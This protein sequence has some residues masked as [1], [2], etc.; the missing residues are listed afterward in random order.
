MCW[1][2]SR[3]LWAFRAGGRGCWRRLSRYKGSANGLWDDLGHAAALLCSLQMGTMALPTKHL[4]PTDEKLGVAKRRHFQL[5]QMRISGHRA[6][7]L[8][9]PTHQSQA[10]AKLLHFLQMKCFPATCSEATVLTLGGFFFPPSVCFLRKWKDVITQLS[11]RLLPVITPAKLATL[12]RRGKAKGLLSIPMFCG[13][14]AAHQRQTDKQPICWE[15]ACRAS[16]A[17]VRDS[18]EHTQR[19]AKEKPSS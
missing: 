11:A 1:C 13:K 15:A 5:G 2:D 4:R 18:G 7:I 12:D 17:A 6:V 10:I 19:C 8:P 16:W 14:Q 3:P 9:V